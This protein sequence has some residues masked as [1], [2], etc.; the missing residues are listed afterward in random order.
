MR[1]SCRQRGSG[2]SEK[3]S[4]CC[5]CEDQL[6]TAPGEPFQCT[7]RPFHCTGE[8]FQCTM[9]VSIARTTHQ[10]LFRPVQ[11]SAA[12][13]AIARAWF[14]PLARLI[15]PSALFRCLFG[16]CSL[17]PFKKR[18]AHQ[19]FRGCMSIIRDHWP[20]IEIQAKCR[21]LW[22]TTSWNN[23]IPQN[24][25]G[26]KLCRQTGEKGSQWDGIIELVQ[27]NRAL[28]WQGEMRVTFMQEV[29]ELLCPQ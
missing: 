5:C 11:K 28:P 10:G 24:L 3:D 26:T 18:G 27:R 8:A 14:S 13:S 17:L 21:G 9:W 15:E 22:S 20:E 25:V 23:L 12:N 19:Q 4:P 2:I 1:L 16:R 7:S 29:K 6:S